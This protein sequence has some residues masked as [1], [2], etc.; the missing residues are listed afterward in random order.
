M[1][2]GVEVRREARGRRAEITRAAYGV[3]ARHGVHRAS[4][5]M[6]A[7]EAG[8][9]KALVLYHFGSKDNLVLAA[10]EWALA[11]TAARIRSS[12]ADTPAG[13][14]SIAKLMDAVWV[15]PVQN[16]DFFRFYLD[17]VEHQTRAPD[18]ARLGAAS[19]QAINGHYVE[20]IEAGVGAG[21]FDVADSS[22]AAS[23]MR[24]LIEGMFLQWL[25]TDDWSTNHG[26]FRDNCLA[27]V[28]LLLGA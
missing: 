14:S 19:R 9:S 24:A 20:V 5:K 23:Q 2:S 17:G 16:R 27:G 13:R 10:L 11:G 21:A 8:V 6:V 4:L 15:G 12:L 7:V 28:L 26:D 3:M 1:T 22:E 18:F 25:Q